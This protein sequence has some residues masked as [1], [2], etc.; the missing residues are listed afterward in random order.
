MHNDTMIARR[1]LMAFAGAGLLMRRA[2]RRKR[3]SSNSRRSCQSPPKGCSVVSGDISARAGA[4]STRRRRNRS[5]ASLSDLQRWVCQRRYFLAK[6][7]SAF[8]ESEPGRD[9]TST[10]AFDS[11]FNRSTQHRAAPR[12]RP[13][14]LLRA[15]SMNG[16]ISRARSPPLQPSHGKAAFPQL[17][18]GQAAGSR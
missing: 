15:D 14:L 18:W 4:S 8:L 11:H 9:H 10:S 13:C 16:N 7:M 1:R 2:G 6:R 12:R 5:C 17:S 3:N